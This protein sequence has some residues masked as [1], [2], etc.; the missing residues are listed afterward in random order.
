MMIKPRRG[1]SPTNEPASRSSAEQRPVSGP[2]IREGL[3]TARSAMNTQSQEFD[4]YE[5]VLADLHAQLDQ[6]NQAIELLERLRRGGVPH[7]AVELR[8]GRSPARA[9][10][11]SSR[12]SGNS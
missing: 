3:N 4:P 5:A 2:D 8:H 6:I 12:D 11:F 1:N 7:S 9:P 10:A